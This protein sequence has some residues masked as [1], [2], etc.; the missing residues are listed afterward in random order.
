[1]GGYFLLGNSSKNAILAPPTPI[2]TQRFGFR[3]DIDWAKS[4]SKSNK[5]AL[6]ATK[7]LKNRPV[8][9]LGNAKSGQAKGRNSS[10]LGK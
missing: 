5:C 7:K 10:P 8:Q 9:A 2:S 3:E 4:R 1:L 6:I